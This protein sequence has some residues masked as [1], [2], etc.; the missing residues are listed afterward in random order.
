MVAAGAAGAIV[1]G[2]VG[3]AEAAIPAGKPLLVAVTE[4][5]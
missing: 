2:P 4:K 1:G 3:V 5:D